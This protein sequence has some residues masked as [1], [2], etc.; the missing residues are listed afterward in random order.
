MLRLL[1]PALCALAVWPSISSANEKNAVY[2]LNPGD[3]ILFP[4][5]ARRL[6]RGS[7]CTSRWQH[8]LPA[9]GASRGCGA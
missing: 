9:G 3:V 1:L 2:L 5:G 4:F 6:K 8:H 7:T